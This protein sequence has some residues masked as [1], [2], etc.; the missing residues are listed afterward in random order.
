[1][2]KAKL[3][4][5]RAVGP[6]IH[7]LGKNVL[8][9]RLS[10]EEKTAGRIV[11]PDKARAKPQRSKMLAVGKPPSGQTAGPFPLAQQW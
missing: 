10:A 1:M 8:V 11:L 4:E 7:P 3:R 9:E 2:A 6:G 5:R